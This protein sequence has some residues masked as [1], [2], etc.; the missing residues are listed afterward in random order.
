VVEDHRGAVG[1]HVAGHPALDPHGLE[2]LAV[3]AAVEHGP[4]LLGRLDELLGDDDHVGARL[5][6]E[7]LSDTTPYVDGLG[8]GFWLVQPVA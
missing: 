2:R 6:E 4:A 8:E 1:H 7:W 3:L 5:V